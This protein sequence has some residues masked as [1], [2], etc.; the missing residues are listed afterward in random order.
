MSDDRALTREEEVAIAKEIE[1]GVREVRE[2]AFS[3]D[4]ALQYVLTLADKLRRGEIAARHVFGDDEPEGEPAAAAESTENKRADTFLKQV[5]E[6]RR[7]AEERNKLVVEAGRAMTSKAR[8]ARIEKRLAAVA[9]AVRDV[10][11]ETQIGATHVQVLVD[12]LKEAQRL[13]DTH[14]HEVRRLEQRLDHSAA[15]ILQYAARIRAGEKDAGRRFRA[16]AAQVVEAADT[17]REARRKA[18][19]VLREVGMSAEALR[20]SL[21]TIRLG[22]MKAQDG[23]KRL[24][25]A[26]LRL[27]VSIAKR[28]MNRGLAFLDLIQEGNIGLMRALE[29]FEWRRGY[30]FSTYAAR[31]IR[32]AVRRAIT[33]QVRR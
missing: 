30:K 2:A 14:R 8:R 28:H 27:V 21:H 19:Q 6:L 10:L 18:Q 25:E 3:L 12:K 24:I 20:A 13:I 31:W 15:N 22:E 16:P 7:L 4:L 32:Q 5:S 33:D 23:K 17:I 9:Q 26:N 1:S 11:L 29:K